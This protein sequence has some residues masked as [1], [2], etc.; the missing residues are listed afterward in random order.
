MESNSNIVGK[1]I[2]ER[3]LALGLTKFALSKKIGIGHAVL[4]R[5]EKGVDIPSI[6]TLRKI[7]EPLGFQLLELVI[8][9]GHLYPDEVGLE[10]D[11]VFPEGLD[12][13][14]ARE[15]SKEPVETQ[16]AIVK[17]L[18]IAKEITPRVD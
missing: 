4:G 13:Y 9:A 3:R 7:A 18:K 2:Q 16:H 14:V 11:K 1:A 5:I 10:G 12:S 6:P 15:L 17:I 8:L